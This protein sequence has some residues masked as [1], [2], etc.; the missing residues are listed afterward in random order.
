MKAFLATL[1]I[2]TLAALVSSYLL[3]G[4]SIDSVS[5]AMV[6]ALVLA[7]LNAFVKPIIILLTLPVTLVTL[8]FFLIVINMLMIQ[9]AANMVP[10]F[11]VENWW[12]AFWYSILLSL[13]TGMIQ[14]L[15]G[16]PAK[17]KASE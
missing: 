4:V 5:T 7:L 17:E 8:G 16:K 6:V 3:P 9:L 11:E 14:S 15:V 2:T 1:M 13:V 12:A 10:G